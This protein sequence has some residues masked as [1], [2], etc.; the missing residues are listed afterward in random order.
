MKRLQSSLLLSALLAGCARMGN[1]PP[2]PT[3]RSVA[4]LPPR[5]QTGE[6]LAVAGTSLL[7]RYAV[8]TERVTVADVLGIALREQLERRGIA[9]AATDALPAA[10]DARTP[11]TAA[12]AAEIAHRAHIDDP[13]LFVTI[14]RWEPDN[15]THPAFVIVALDATLID[16]ATGTVLWHLH[17]SAR[18]IATPGTVTS[19]T[20]HEIAARQA[21]AEL[22]TSWPE[23]T[24][25]PR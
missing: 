12:A 9:L 5:D 15:P 20:A 22:L 13:A 8:R 14:D 21:A 25:A 23:T 11:T 3:V 4:V 16:P 1:A 19:G 17:R 18:P 6:S 7:E 2:P 24:A 10:A